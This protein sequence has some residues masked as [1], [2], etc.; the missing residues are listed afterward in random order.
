MAAGG[1]RRADVA[2]AI[3]QRDAIGQGPATERGD[4]DARDALRGR[5]HAAAAGDRNP[6]PLL[7]MREV[8]DR[9][10]FGPA[11]CEARRRGGRGIQGGG[12]CGDRVAAGGRGVERGRGRGRQTHIA[13]RIGQGNGEGQSTVRAGR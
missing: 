6:P 12:H 8:V 2:G 11:E 4:V 9:V 13:D 7:E 10:R 3:R 5:G 1:G